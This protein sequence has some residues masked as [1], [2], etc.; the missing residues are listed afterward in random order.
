VTQSPTDPPATVPRSGGRPRTSA[1]SATSEV[2][3]GE[4]PPIFGGSDHNS[5]PALPGSTPPGADSGSG[6]SHVRKSGGL[7]TPVKALI[8]LA[9]VVVLGAAAA[10]VLGGGGGDSASGP[11]GAVRSFFNAAKDKDCDRMLDLVTEASWSQGGSVDKATALDQC[12]ESVDSPD[13]FPGQADITATKV[14]DESDDT[15]TVEVT[16]EV[17][18]AEP[19]TETLAV[20]KE[21]GT[22]VVDFNA[23]AAATDA[24]AADAGDTPATTAAPEG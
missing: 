14:L 20:A 4:R 10:L 21:D 11:D 5:G 13:F 24:P 7:G 6:P 17:G 12:A 22:W 8:G 15:A 3:S 18:E 9:V 1:P 16:T 2:S 19:V 23:P